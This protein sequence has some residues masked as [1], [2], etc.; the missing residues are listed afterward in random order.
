MSSW[1]RAVFLGI[2]P[3]FFNKTYL[4]YSLYATLISRLINI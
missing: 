1:P 2:E 3:V 4:S